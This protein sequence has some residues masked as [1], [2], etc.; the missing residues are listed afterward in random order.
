MNTPQNK[1]IKRNLE[2]WQII[3]LCL[4]VCDFITI[5]LSYFLALW[6]RFDGVYRAIPE[7]YLNPY[8]SF[9]LPAAA[10]SILIFLL[11]LSFLC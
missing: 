11:F 7:R 4:M 5:H 2:H 6:L 1:A 9:I 10:V 8:C 3:A